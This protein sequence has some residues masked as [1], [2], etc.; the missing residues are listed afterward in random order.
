MLG[1]HD[2][3]SSVDFLSR[4][5]RLTQVVDVTFNARHATAGSCTLPSIPVVV[6]MQSALIPA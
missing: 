5:F 4:A 6:R 1:T 2:N 3:L